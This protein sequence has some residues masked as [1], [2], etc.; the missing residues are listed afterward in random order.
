M[1]TTEEPLRCSVFH[2]TKSGFDTLPRRATG[3]STEMLCI[4][5]HHVLAMRGIHSGA[6]KVR[7]CPLPQANS[8]HSI[9]EF[10]CNEKVLRTCTAL[11]TSTAWE[12]AAQRPLL[13][14]ESKS[15]QAGF[16]SLG[17]IGLA[18]LPKQIIIGGASQRRLLRA[19]I[20]A[21]RPTRTPGATKTSVAIQDSASITIVDA[22]MSKLGMEKSCEPVQ[23]YDLCEITTLSAM[24]IS[25]R[26]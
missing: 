16:A 19:P 1:P 17:R 3:D 6:C 22:K 12:L 10:A 8:S 9:R 11:F 25:P 21:P 5:L 18:G 14:R 4:Q 24:W 2:E 20:T 7:R 13:N 15:A 23:I 26:L